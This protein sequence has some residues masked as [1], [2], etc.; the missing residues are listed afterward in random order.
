MIYRFRKKGNSIHPD[1]QQN[2]SFIPF[3]QINEYQ[4]YKKWDSQELQQENDHEADKRY[5]ILQMGHISW[6][7]SHLTIPG[8]AVRIGLDQEGIFPSGSLRGSDTCEYIS[9]ISGLF[10]GKAP[11]FTTASKRFLPFFIT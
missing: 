10:D 2:C 11:V 5:S 1:L 3:P 9:P 8:V 7:R 4:E 6:H